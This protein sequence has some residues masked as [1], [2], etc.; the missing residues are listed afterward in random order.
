MHNN[1]FRSNNKN[2]FKK[3]ILTYL[4]KISSGDS[5]MKR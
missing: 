5:S 3:N 2:S 4:K 1:Y